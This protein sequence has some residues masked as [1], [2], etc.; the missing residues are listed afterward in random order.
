MA[1][2]SCRLEAVA[3]LASP[4]DPIIVRDAA[5]SKEDAYAPVSL[6]LWVAFPGA[7]LGGQ[8]FLWRSKLRKLT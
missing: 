7:F 2:V 6:D 4:G 8:S 3:T 1:L 5:G